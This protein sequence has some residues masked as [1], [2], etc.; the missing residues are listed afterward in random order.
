MSTGPELWQQTQGTLTHFVSAMGTTG[1]ITGTGRY[2][3]SQNPQIQVIGAQPAEG[4]SIPGIRKWSDDYLPEIFDP[5]VVNEY[6]LIGQ[7]EAEE[8]ARQ[9]ARQEGIF[10]GI[11]S[12]GALLAALR[13]AERV[14]N[15]T[16]VFIVCDRGDRYLSQGVFN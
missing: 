16:I 9:L 8:M 5:A 10:A 2:L 11:S 6:E 12:A 15:A 13:V 14:Q 3:K 7:D 1:T 4:A